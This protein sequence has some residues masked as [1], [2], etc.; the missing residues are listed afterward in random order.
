MGIFEYFPL[1]LDVKDSYRKYREKDCGREEATEKLREE[2]ANELRDADDR[3]QVLIGLAEVTGRRKEL[4]EELLRDAEAAFAALEKAFPEARAVLRAKKKTVCDPNKCGP[5]AKYRKK[6]IYRPYWQL[7]DTFAY[8]IMGQELKDAGF[9]GWYIIA[10]KV[11]EFIHSEDC[12]EQGMYFSLCPPDRIPTTTKELEALDYVPLLQVRHDEYLFM[13]K[14]WVN[15][16]SEEKYTFFRKIGNFPQ[17][18]PPTNEHLIGDGPHSCTSQ[19]PGFGDKTYF[20][21][22]ERD[23]FRGYRSFGLWPAKIEK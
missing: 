3:P 2:Y 5:E 9:E 17:A 21:L 11:R 14:V 19:L 22:L 16:R 1:I 13:G 12:C 7:G 23:V 18:A 10:R 20:W 4:T 8:A 15:S 6:T